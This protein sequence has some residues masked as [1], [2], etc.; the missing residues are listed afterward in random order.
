MK[1]LRLLAK[2]VESSEGK[3]NRNF[4]FR[5]IGYVW[6]SIILISLGLYSVKNWNTLSSISFDLHVGW[7]FLAIVLETCRRTTGAIRWAL[8]VNSNNKLTLNSLFS[9]LHTFFVSNL[10]AYIP[11]SIWYIGARFYLGKQ[12]GT[13]VATTSV[14]LIYDTILLLW[15][16]SIVGVYFAVSVLDV[17]AGLLWTSVTGMIV[18]TVCLIHPQISSYFI[19]FINKFSADSLSVPDITVKRGTYLMILS[20]ATWLVGGAALCSLI[21]GLG[22]PITPELVVKFISL[23]AVAWVIG[24]VSIWAPAG[25]GVR[26]GMFY[27]GLKAHYPAPAPLSIAILA[28]LMT[29]IPDIL[30]A[31]ALHLAYVTN[32]RPPRPI[33]RN[34]HM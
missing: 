6:I 10:A 16:G 26:E 30:L 22:F 7:V 17:S 23:N 14:S 2:N 12:K 3:V 32:S 29:V 28:R 19:N 31:C 4:I 15:S 25:I 24:F 1:Y 13:S 11:G 21:R 20:V 18:G 33:S 8:I 9:H 27:L 5:W 34:Y